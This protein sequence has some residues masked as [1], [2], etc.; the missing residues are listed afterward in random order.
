M[1]LHSVSIASRTI[2]TIDEGEKEPLLFIHGFPLDH[3]MWRFQAD[4]FAKTN[5]VIIPDLAGFGTSDPAGDTMTMA[6]Y[7]D[8]LVAIL[9]RQEMT[10]PAVV[11]SL[12]MGGY[13]ALELYHKYRD[14]VKGIVFCDTRASNDSPEVAKARQILAEE[15]LRD[16]NDKLVENMT[17]KLFSE[18]SRTE[19]PD[20]VKETQAAMRLASRQGIAAASRGMAVR[21]DF[22]PL[23]FDWD[24]PCCLICG[25]KD[26]ITPPAEM[27]TMADAI[28]GSQFFRVPHVGHMAPL[29]SPDRVN[30]IIRAFIKSV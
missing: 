2:R 20:R 10:T 27:Q 3:S 23:I 16:G 8:D 22:R 30:E 25:D 5:R 4:C 19:L 6:D 28:A 26:V 14:R 15:V 21:R 9:D 17:A 18:R 7:A 29:E 1:K 13:I 11:V 12:S 24:V